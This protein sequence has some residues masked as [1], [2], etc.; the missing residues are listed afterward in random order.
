MIYTDYLIHIDE[1]TGKPPDYFNKSLECLR[2]RGF[3]ILPITPNNF[4]L[5][6]DLKI[7]AHSP[8]THIKKIT[9]PK[10]D[11]I[12]AAEHDIEGFFIAEGDLLLND[13]VDL[14]TIKFLKL[15][16]P[17]WIAYKKK[18]S[19]YIV[20]NFLIY[21]PI[22]HYQEFKNRLNNQKRMVYSDRF[23]TKLVAEGFMDILDES[24]GYEIPHYSNVIND[25]RN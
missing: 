2:S 25:Y 6:I 18:L 14:T 20:G 1:K 19:N 3:N 7:I 22:Q 23:F 17:T 24:L 11:G 4:K 5:G 9:I 15:K 10:I 16:K 21:I 13:N 12:I 8:L